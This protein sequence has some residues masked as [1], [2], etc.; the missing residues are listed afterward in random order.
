MHGT[1]W[2][3]PEAK[4]RQEMFKPVIESEYHDLPCNERVRF[5]A[6]E[7]PLQ[8]YLGRDPNSYDW[9]VDVYGSY[10]PQIPAP[11]VVAKQSSG[12]ATDLK[13]V[14]RGWLDERQ[15]NAA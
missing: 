9:C 1:Y 2:F 3:N 11:V 13:R 7:H 4:T 15:A 10:N 12:L 14:V 5:W 8:V 6:G